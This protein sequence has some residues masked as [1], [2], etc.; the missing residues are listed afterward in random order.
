MNKPCINYPCRWIYKLFGTDE[1]SIRQAV[2]KI[3]AKKEY[4]LGSSRKS[5]G[6]KY[7][8]VHLETDVASE[9]E[10]NKIYTSLNNDKAVIRIL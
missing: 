2:I 8:S 1:E 3:M 9:E 4:H 5:S 7:V 6:G 10:R